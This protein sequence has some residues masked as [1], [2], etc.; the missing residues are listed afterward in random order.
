MIY[1][2]EKI[3]EKDKG[4]YLLYFKALIMMHDERG[5]HKVPIVSVV[6]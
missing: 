1:T 5:G 2:E 3:Y 6:R 4:T